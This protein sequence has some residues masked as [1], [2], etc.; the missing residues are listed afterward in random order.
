[1]YLDNLCLTLMSNMSKLEAAEIISVHKSALSSLMYKCIYAYTSMYS[2]TASMSHSYM[3]TCSHSTMCASIKAVGV[4]QDRECG[5]MIGVS[6]ACKH[7]FAT[8]RP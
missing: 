2:H 5:T 6:S 4:L 7:M 3:Y 1:M 8:L